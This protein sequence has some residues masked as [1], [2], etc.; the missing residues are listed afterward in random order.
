MIS[1]RRKSIIAIILFLVISASLAATRTLSGAETG[2][3]IGQYKSVT[4]EIVKTLDRRHFREQI[5]DD[6]LSAK[7][8]DNYLSSLDPNKAYFLQSDI[9]EFEQYRKLLDD[10]LLKG[11]NA[12]GFTIYERFRKRFTERMDTVVAMLKDEELSFDFNIDES[13][14]SDSESAEW[15]KSIDEANDL[16]RKRIKASLLDQKLAGEPVEKVRKQ[17]LKRYENQITRVSQS[18]QDAIYER[19]INSLTELYDPHTSYLSPRS[20][21]NFN[22]NM[23]LSLEGIGAVLSTED[24]NTKVVRLVTG[25]PAEKQGELKP[26]DLITGVGQEDG[27]IIDVVGWRL[28]EVVE[29]IRGPKGSTVRLRVDS[30]SPTQVNKIIAIK[31]DK[32]K[33]EDQAAQKAVL[34]IDYN[35]DKLRF[36]VIDIPNFYLDFQAYR[37]G[38]PNYRSTTRDVRRLIAELSEDDVDGLIVD[39]R[40][41]GG[42]SLQEA[43]TLTELFI[44]KGPVVQIGN[45]VRNQIYPSTNAPYYHGPLLVLIDRL[46]ASASEIFAGAIQDYD[47]GI[48]VGSQTFGKGTVQSLL[49]LKSRGDLKLTESKFYRVSGESTQHRGVLPDIELPESID[50]DQVGESSY[51]TALEWSTTTAVPYQQYLPI[52]ELLPTLVTQ[53]EQRAALNPDFIFL[54]EQK[55]LFDDYANNP[56][57]SLNEKQRLSQKATFEAQSLAIENKR[58][59]A[60]NES[61]FDTYEALKEYNE[62]RQ[63]E[64][65]ATAGTTVIDTQ[66]DALLTEAG[67]IFGDFISAVTKHYQKASTAAR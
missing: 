29:K 59:K 14:N 32:V 34:D 18:S 43:R 24:E 20:A 53:H 27:E 55:T 23:S 37:D 3:T 66:D 47:R 52:D 9:D 8:L 28:D 45:G 2:D 40:G 63:D 42:G 17:L 41:N 10:Q 13:L 65:R 48:V 46:S 67:Y 60:K 22:I 11:D 36:G 56:M 38:D 30:G 31:R 21:E 5:I 12:S 50:K 54:A 4:L 1:N 15:P 33:L 58:R 57:I 61:L 26:A 39:L 6:A 19:Y 51:D 7:F 62:K 49:P 25:G 64:R 44:D 16:W 35:G